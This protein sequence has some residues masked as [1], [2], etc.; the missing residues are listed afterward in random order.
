MKPLRPPV[1]LAEKT[2]YPMLARLVQPLTKST[3]YV[4]RNA[5][6]ELVKR[7]K[8]SRRFWR[9]KDEFLVALRKGRVEAVGRIY[10]FQ[11]G[12][13][14]EGVLGRGVKLPH[15][16]A[17][18]AAILLEAGLKRLEA[19]GAEKIYFFKPHESRWHPERHGFRKESETY[20]GGLYARSGGGKIPNV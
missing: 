8:K 7:L 6:R 2:D 10:V 17:E 19:M 3:D 13:R 1:Y 9:T 5:S 16:T 11:N 4:T 18:D 20:K 14:R 15:A 12:C